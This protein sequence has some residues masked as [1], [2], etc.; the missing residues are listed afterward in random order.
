[1]IDEMLKRLK[2]ETPKFFKRVAIFGASLSATGL[3][4]SQ[5]PNVPQNIVEIASRC[6][7]MGLVAAAVAKMAVVN[8][9]ELKP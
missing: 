3:T 1:M 2:A 6:I 7:W 4:I 5:I 9:E 8:P